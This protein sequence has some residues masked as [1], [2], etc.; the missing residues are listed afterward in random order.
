MKH[1]LATRVRGWPH[2]S[3]H[4]DVEQGLLPIDWAGDVA[5]GRYRLHV[6]IEDEGIDPQPIPLE[7]GV[8]LLSPGQAPARGSAQPPQSRWP[9]RL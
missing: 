5:A 4:R 7:L 8:Q 6:K 9:H 3:F 1:G 2:S